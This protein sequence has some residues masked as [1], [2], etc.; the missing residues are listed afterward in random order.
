MHVF[1]VFRCL[2]FSA[3]PIKIV[4]HGVPKAGRPR[5]SDSHFPRSCR[6]DT[7][8]IRVCTNGSWLMD[9]ESDRPQCCAKHGMDD[10]DIQGLQRVAWLLPDTSV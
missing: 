3:C 2:R 6:G 5:Y 8:H 7:S 9:S 4:L 10:Q 1:H